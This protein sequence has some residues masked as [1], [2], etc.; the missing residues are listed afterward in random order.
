M[1]L[2]FSPK[3]DKIIQNLHFFYLFEHIFIAN[4]LKKL[5]KKNYALTGINQRN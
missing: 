3:I 2:L 4:Y 1:H 5:K